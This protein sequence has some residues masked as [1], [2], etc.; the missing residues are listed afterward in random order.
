MVSPAHLLIF[1]RFPETGQCK[2]R[3]IPALGAAG[4]ARLQKKLTEHAVSTA[5]RLQTM[6]S[7]SISIHH[8]GGES[9]AVMK[10]LDVKECYEQRG[11][12]IG[13]RM[14]AAFARIFKLRTEQAVLIGSDIPE[15]AAGLLDRAFTALHD[16]E[17]VIGP[18]L[19]GGYYLIGMRV[20]RSA[21]LL[22]LLFDEITWSA[23]DVYRQTA[24]RLS[25]RG[26]GFARLPALRDIDTAEDLDLLEGRGWI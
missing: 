13:A 9:E 21:E 24:E 20:G 15:I 14:K 23:A 16:H 5:K 22:P 8:R 3:L 1:T 25:S 4:A 10:W 6:R 17:V 7:V 26:A 2:T 18:S 19:D 11:S 12:D